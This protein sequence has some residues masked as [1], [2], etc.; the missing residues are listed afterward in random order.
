MNIFIVFL[1]LT[2]H[3]IA[4]FILQ[5][6]KMAI[7]KSSNNWHLFKHVFIYS[8]AWFLVMVFVLPG[9]LAIPFCL[10]TFVAHF[11][12][13]YFT[14]RLSSK[15]YKEG[16]RHSFFLVIGIDQLLHYFQLFLTYQYLINS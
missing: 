12:T 4:D 16:K 5:S 11:I 3:Y 14:S 1:I 13:D 15:L 8:W 10:I 9:S 2:V 6:D 7:N